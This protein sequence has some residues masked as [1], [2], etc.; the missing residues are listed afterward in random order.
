MLDELL[1]TEDP[2]EPGKFR[3]PFPKY[4]GY[5]RLPAPFMGRHYKAWWR[6]SESK[7]EG[8]DAKD[9]DNLAAFQEWRAAYAVVSQW[10]LEGVPPGDI[11]PTGDNVPLE[12]KQWAQVLV[13]RYISDKLNLKKWLAPSAT[14]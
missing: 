4:P 8:Q 7:V 10:S 11:D 2:N 12:V 6:A 1:A 3:S 9:I 14:T 13:I 5:I